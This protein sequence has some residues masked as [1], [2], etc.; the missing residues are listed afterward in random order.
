MLTFLRVFDNPLSKYFFLLLKKF[1]VCNGCFGI[2]TKIKRGSETSFWCIFSS[3]FFHKNV[4]LFNTLWMSK[5]SVSYLFSFPRYQTK[6][7]IK[8]LYR[9]LMMSQTIR[10]MLDQPL[11]QWLTGRKRGEDGNTKIWISREGK[12]L[13]RWN[14]K[15]FSLFLKVCHLVKNKKLMNNSGHKL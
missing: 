5:V 3:W 12:E 7:I 2:F 6:C 11:K 8:F 4:F 10:F 13:F 14:K 15:H 9:Q 1:L